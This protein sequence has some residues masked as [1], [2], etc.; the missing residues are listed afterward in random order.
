MLAHSLLVPAM[1]SRFR[2]WLAWLAAGC[3]L[4]GLGSCGGGGGSPSTPPFILASL[5]GFPTGAA[6]PGMLASSANTAAAVAVVD[7]D[8]GNPIASA[9][10]V[11]NGTAL[12]YVATRQDYE[13][14]L[15]INPGSPVALSVTV[16]GSTYAVSA[17]QFNAYPTI[18]APQPQANWSS[19]SANLVAWSGVAPWAGALYALAV[20]DT[21]GQLVWPS[22]D[23]IQVL[24]STTT[25]YSIDAFAL[26]A[27]N[28][29]VLVGV[30]TA[31][32]IPGA[33]PSS[34]IVIGG[35]NYVPITVSS[36]P[37]SSLVSIAIS[38][39]NPTLGKGGSLQLTATGTYSD[40]SSQVLTT[41]VAWASTTPAVATV[42]PSGLA[43]G[44]DFGSATVSAS[45]GAVSGSTTLNVFQPSPSPAPPL[46][47]SVTY[48]IDY[49]HS[50]RAVFGTPV[51]F[52]SGP[53]WSVALP[54]AVSY[55]LIAGGK[56]F[57]TTTTS[58]PNNL[59]G[60]SL[61]AF[62]AQTGNIAWGP[63]AIPGTYYWSGHAYDHGKIFV[64]NFDG[65]LRSF[66]AATGQ[67]GWS[68]QL[69]GQYAFSAPP[70]A[71]NGVV[72]VAGAGSGGTLY[73][74]NAVNGGVLWTAGVANGDMSSPAASADG[75]FVSY[76]CQVYKFDPLSGS[77]LWHYAGGCS[78]GGGKTAAY[79]NG[80]LYVRDPTNPPA[81]VFDATNGSLVGNF[82]A[83]PIPALSTQ[84][85]YF[86]NAGTLRAIDLASQQVWWS[87]AGDGQLV[88]A[89]IVINQ[90]VIVGSSSG[91]VYALDAATGAQVWVGSAGGAISAPDEQ[92]VVQPLTGFGAGEGLLVVPAG[93]VLTGWRL[94]GP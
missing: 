79:A 66:D 23:S 71:V 56:V 13:G 68:T 54:G 91:N 35:F 67:A 29:L 3:I 62:D 27:G 1:T 83:T 89:P 57:V 46:G 32:P 53:A 5:I 65:L 11:V 55:P 76:P 88:S 82:S 26:S 59:Y 85:G 6:P 77:V 33:D 19:Q 48:Q 10:V 30:A 93:N 43:T 31:L 28:R 16:D 20:L 38:P 17:A 72:Y 69:P 58:T 18:T 2:P 81:K 86:L 75:V 36:G 42:S 61:Y 7:P 52:P 24:P 12:V 92:N 22:S 60:T 9:A 41:Q 39:N 45:L 14:E 63:V 51:V 44:V 73:A 25:S 87:F 50:G 49:A 74:I 8:S 15:T 40:G 80:R 78:G 70:T 4:L 64:V 90:F 94:S 47:Q 84:T 34:A 37:S 21:N